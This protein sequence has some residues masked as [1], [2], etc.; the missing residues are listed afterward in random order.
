MLMAFRIPCL[1]VGALLYDT[2][3]LAAAVIGLSI[4]LPWMAVLIANDRLP[5]C[6]S[7]FQRAP[8]G[9]GQR[10]ID[11]QTMRD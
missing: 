3:W 2:P 8:S 10:Q 9:P 11:A 1:I 7:T 4:P 5:R 6:R